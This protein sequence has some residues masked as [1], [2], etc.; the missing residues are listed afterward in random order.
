MLAAFRHLKDEL[1]QLRTGRA[2]PTLVSDIEVEAYGTKMTVKELGQITAPEATVILISPWDKSVIAS[3][4]SGISKS[5]LGFNPVVDG[6]VIR[7]N[8]PSLTAER[9]EQ[10]IKQM[11]QLLEKYKVE[12]RQVRHE[13]I[14][15]VR[16]QEKNG[17]I[18]EDE[19]ERQSKE[20]QK[21]HD[22]YI[23]QIDDIGKA[24]EEQLREV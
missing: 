22:E 6:D 20:I 15:R 7:I 21:I 19:E 9:R 4:S 10:L 23:E 1:A 24:K 12:I 5:N 11:H 8:I 3:I 13:Y 17:E 18:G 14:E 16:N 2:T